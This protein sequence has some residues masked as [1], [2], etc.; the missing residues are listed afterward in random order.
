MKTL[1]IVL[2]AE[3]VLSQPGISPASSSENSAVRD[4]A[5]AKPLA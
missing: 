5:A 1:I 3:I 4:L 2:I